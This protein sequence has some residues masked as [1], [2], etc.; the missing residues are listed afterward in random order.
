MSIGRFKKYYIS[1]GFEDTDLG[2]EMHLRRKKFKLIKTPL[3]HLTSYDQMQY[4]NSNSRRAKLLRVT[5]AKFYLQHL[6]SDI[7]AVVGN[8]FRFE[9]PIASRIRDLLK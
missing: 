3:L 6:D 8:Y 7:F 2:F 5:A 4:K 1:Y 9:K